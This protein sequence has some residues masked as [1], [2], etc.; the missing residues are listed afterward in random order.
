LKRFGRDVGFYLVKAKGRRSQAALLLGYGGGLGCPLV[1]YSE[2]PE[3]HALKVRAIG[4]VLWD[5]RS[6]AE[7]SIE[8]VIERFRLIRP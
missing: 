7:S 1:Y 8:V 3:P 4:G 6:G 5:G 2:F